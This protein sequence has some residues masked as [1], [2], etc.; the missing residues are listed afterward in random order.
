M[1]LVKAKVDAGN[2]GFMQVKPKEKK[3]T[4]KK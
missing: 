4:N 3:Q 2:C 1:R